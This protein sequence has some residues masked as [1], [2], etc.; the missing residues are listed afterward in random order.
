MADNW[1][2]ITE[3]AARLTALGDAVDRS[4]LSRYLKQHAEALPTERRG[5]QN[6][7]DFE[8]LVAHRSENVRLRSAPGAPAAPSTPTA[9]AP[10]AY[11]GPRRFT[12]TQA[13]GAARKAM[14]DAELREMEVARRRGELTPAAEVD[15]AGR[16]A[17][18]LMRAAFDRA[19]ESEA[20][21]LALKFGWDERQVLT[22]LKG[23]ARL[24]V[25]VFHQ[26]M[27]TRLDMIRREDEAAEGRRSD[28]PA[29]AVL[30]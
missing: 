6:L 8:A 28:A 2:S 23:F 11:P 14:A 15:R 10:D 27:L 4:T 3:A 5:R 19:V 1:I 17:I 26:E 30:Q 13:D 29:E 18:V 16:D 22:A 12:G 20:S 7:V 24:G 21:V 25:D 9:A